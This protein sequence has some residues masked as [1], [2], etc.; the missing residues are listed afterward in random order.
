MK[1]KYIYISL[2]GVFLFCIHINAKAQN[3]VSIHLLQSVPQSI[4]TNPSFSPD[5]KVFVGFPALS[6]VYYG[7]SHSGF[8]YKDLVRRRSDDSLLV[9]V[10]NMLSKLKDRNYLSTQYNMELLSFGF[11][12]KK[13]Y[14]SFSAAEKVSMRFS[15]PGDLLKLFWGGN[16]QFIE[17]P[18]NFSGIGANFIHYREYAIG[19]KREFSSDL[20][21]GLRG[22][23]LYGKSNLWTEKSEISLATDPSTHALTA[24]SHII[25]NMSLP[26]ATFDE[27][28]DFEPLDYL[29]NNKNTGMAFDIGANYKINS[30]FSV[31]A[32]VIDIGK[33]SWKTGIKNFISNDVNFTFEG[34]DL[35]DFFGKDSTSKDGLELLL[36]SLE[37]TFEFKETENN[38]SNW[39]PGIVY[40]SGI[41]HLTSKDKVGLL[42]RA[43][44]FNGRI[45][46][47]YTLSY[48]KRIANFV[49]AC[50]TYSIMN[51]SYTNVG[52]GL[53][54][55]LSALQIYAFNDNIYGLLF[56]TSAKNSNIHFG[57]NL[58]FGYRIKPPEKPLIY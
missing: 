38:Y 5:A 35:N 18:A 13:N 41:Y 32:S 34:I 1:K 37:K 53:S 3:D 42:V 25:L 48:N 36:D 47:S 7:I 23:L 49:S 22:K 57:I 44:V 56:P 50:A 14:V 16:T 31:A 39:L 55:Q 12:I 40:L 21:V 28:K 29:L 19:Y 6:S 20:S 45:F 26:E 30:K 43:D 8:A 10:D 52:F 27:N 17:Q 51:R 24:R 2:L 58:L 15:Y 54:L 9:D 4:Y 46:P 11:K 33:I